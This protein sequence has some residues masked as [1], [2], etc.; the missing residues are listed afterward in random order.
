MPC[1]GV[2]T[3]ASSD[4]YSPRFLVIAFKATIADPE[5]RFDGIMTQV[6]PGESIPGLDA[7]LVAVEL[8]IE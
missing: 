4:H 7:L 5:H 1:E 8:V 3:L 6:L 2:G